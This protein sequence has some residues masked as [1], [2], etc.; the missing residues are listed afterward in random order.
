MDGNF[1]IG[2]V[3]GAGKMG[4]LFRR[5]FEQR[6]YPVLIS[7]LETGLSLPELLKTCKFI[8]L[9]LPMEVFPEVVEKMAPYVDN[10][11]W[12]MDICS[13]KLEPARIMRRFLKKGELVAGHPLFGPYEEDLKGKIMVLYP[14]RGKGAYF[15]LS[16]LFNNAGLRVVK[17]PPQRHDEVMG[18]VQ[19]VNHFWLILLGNLIQSANFKVEEVVSLSTPSFLAQLEIL[20]RLAKQDERLYARIQLENPFGR[21]FRKLLCKN[22][23]DLTKILNRRDESAYELFSEIFNQAKEI[24]REIEALLSAK[25]NQK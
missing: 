22:C 21:K 1:K 12:I 5:F 14:L 7:D 24:A 3:G 16:E 18:L 15:W 8:L 4:V 25:V 11:H 23:Q 13:L 19:V 10:H 6:G 17:I 2:I 9:S 20:K